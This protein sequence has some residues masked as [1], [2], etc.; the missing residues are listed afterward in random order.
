MIWKSAALPDLNEVNTL[1]EHLQVPKLIAQLL[2]QRQLTTFAAAKAFFRPQWEALYD[3]YLM[4][5][6]DRAVPRIEKA[7]ATKEKIMIYG[8]YDVDGTTA[9]ALIYSYLN[10]IAEV[11]CYIPDRYA[12]G[13]GVSQKGIDTAKAEGISLIIAL[14]C[15]IK[16]VHQVAYANTLGID[17]II[18]D[19][20]QPGQEL[21]PAHAILD[22][23]QSD[24]TYPFDGLCGCGI[25][26]KLVQAL[27]QPQGA[28]QEQLV[29]YLD[30][31]ATAI[32]ADIVPLVDENRILTYFGLQ[33]LHQAPRPGIAY[34]FKEL[35][36]K[37]TVSDL[38]FKLAP[39][40]N[41][42]GRMEH[43]IKAVRL[44]TATSPEE[45]KPLA[46][47]IEFN[48][49][50]R[51]SKE[52]KITQEALAQVNQSSEVYTSVVYNAHWHK[53]VVGIVASRLIEQYYRPTVVLTQSGDHWAGS[54][55]SVRGFDVYRA[56]EACEDSM[57][58]FGGHKYA[59]GLT[60]ETHQLE[61]FKSKFETVVQAQMEPEQRVPQLAY[62]LEVGL[63]QITPKVY[64]ILTQMAPF[65]PQNMRP[66]FVTHQ[67]K[68]TGGSRV[69]GQDQTHLRLELTDPSG[70]KF[71][72]IAFNQASHLLAVKSQ[73][74][75]SICYTVEENHF[76][77]Q[78]H[79]QL[80]I[81]ALRFD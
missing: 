31:V 1:E 30:L 18:C 73:D 71:T 10:P 34:F 44:L 17:F 4:K 7:I 61:A 55:R 70:V 33:Q 3:P 57:I 66:V 11:L 74:P 42:A 39:R 81:K 21:P 77:N 5:D 35:K 19:H 49:S 12:E 58:Q 62:D 32:A 56:L 79:L 28:T 76:N 24:C 63:D 68:D 20:H 54:V 45:V 22:P 23:K 64:R 43:G 2:A 51:R 67:C 6:M 75:F 48:N 25:G 69:V 13:Y 50:E 59:A 53:G 60:L 9:V 41:A 16:A 36:N 8:D 15:G 47:T 37:A 52:E 80:K 65:G 46:R 26:F 72:G 14:D 78:V 29:P 40:I 38:V 27:M